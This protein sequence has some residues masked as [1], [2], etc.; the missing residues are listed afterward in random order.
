MYMEVMEY[1]TEKGSGGSRIWK[2]GGQSVAKIDKFIFL[3]EN[4]ED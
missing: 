2:L 1:V 3:F 4:G